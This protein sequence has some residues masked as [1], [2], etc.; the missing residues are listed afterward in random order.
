MCLRSLAISHGRWTIE[1][2]VSLN[3]NSISS[4]SCKVDSNI[5]TMGMR[6]EITPFHC[7]VWCTEESF[8]YSAFADNVHTSQCWSFHGEDFAFLQFERMRTTFAIR[9]IDSIFAIHFAIIHS[10]S[11]IACERFTRAKSKQKPNQCFHANNVNPA[12]IYI[13]HT[14]ITMNIQH[15]LRIISFLRFSSSYFVCRI[16]RGGCWTMCS[17]KGCRDK[18]E[19][20]KWERY[21]HCLTILPY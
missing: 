10:R 20:K 9:A 11:R 5:E 6:S 13:S 17:H 14:L 7:R 1:E 2:N 12:I 16:H 18:R 21:A 15:N 3:K 8:T 4:K 19:T